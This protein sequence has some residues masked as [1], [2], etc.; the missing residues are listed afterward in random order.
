MLYPTELR[1]RVLGAGTGGLLRLAT[2]L[3]SFFADTK[4][5]RHKSGGTH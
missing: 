3:T 4:T 1:S 2:F 5:P